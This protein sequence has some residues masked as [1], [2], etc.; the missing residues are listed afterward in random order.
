MA[1]GLKAAIRWAGSKQALAD[2][3]G[4]WPNTVAYWV[5]RGVP[6]ARCLELEKLTRIP[7][8]QLNPTLYP[9]RRDAS[10]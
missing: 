10:R 6:A 5:E 8:E 9:P 1:P 2:A 4:V 3:C 7:R